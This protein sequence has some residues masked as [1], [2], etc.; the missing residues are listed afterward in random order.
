MWVVFDSI[1][2]RTDL[3]SNKGTK[4]SGWVLSGTKKG[5]MDE[6]DTE[7]QKV[8]FDNATADV[9]DKN[10]ETEMLVY[11]FFQSCQSGDLIDIK[12][13]QDGKFKKISSLENK[14]RSV[15]P[16]NS[17]SSKAVVNNSVSDGLAA[18]V[19]FVNALI[20]NGHY[21][22]KTSPEVLLDA[23]NTYRMR[24]KVLDELNPFGDTA[25]F[26]FDDVA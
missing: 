17:G 25:E 8:I 15:L 26:Q 16:E 3:D 20:N 18:A 10:G 24:L 19:G 21:A 9:I 12:F 1:E 14:S 11:E 23:V 5:Y 22:D 7:Y 13:I 6:G 2:H 4:Y